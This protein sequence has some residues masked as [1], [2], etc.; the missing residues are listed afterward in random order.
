MRPLGL[1]LL[2]HGQEVGN[3][4]GEAVQPYDHQRLARSDIAQQS[5]QHRPAAVGT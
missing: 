1:E 5:R 2:D 4:A 3:G